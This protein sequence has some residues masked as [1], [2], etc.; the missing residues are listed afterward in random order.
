MTSRLPRYIKEYNVLQIKYLLELIKRACNSEPDHYPEIL[1]DIETALDKPVY[2]NKVN[3]QILR[4]MFRDGR[5]RG[6]SRKELK[7]KM[8]NLRLF[9]MIELKE[10]LDRYVEVDDGVVIK[11]S[12]L[13][14]YYYNGDFYGKFN[15]HIKRKM[16]KREQLDH[17]IQDWI[18]RKLNDLIRDMRS[19]RK[20]IIG[21]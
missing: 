11:L 9:F 16:E 1:V 5:G 3:N 8:K 13:L 12:H 21:K 15:K 17:K 6:I 7:N 4:N 10:K 18:I 19:T 2:V 20:I 14:N